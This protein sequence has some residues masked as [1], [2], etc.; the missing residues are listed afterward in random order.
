VDHLFNDN[1]A[2]RLW[3]PIRLT[4][5]F[6][7]AFP[8]NFPTV[9]GSPDPTETTQYSASFHQ[10]FPGPNLLNECRIG[11]FR[12]RHH[13]SHSRG[14]QAG[15]SARHGA[16]AP[17]ILSFTGNSP[18]RSLS[19][20]RREQSH[21]TGISV[22]RQPDLGERPPLVP[23]AALKCASTSDPGYD[24]FGGVPAPLSG[25][26][27][28]AV[29]NIN[30]ITGIGWNSG[31]AQNTLLDLAGSL[32]LCFPKRQFSGSANPVFLPGDEETRYRTWR[33]REAPFTSKTI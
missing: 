6:N 21:H 7:V 17:Y 32:S 11:A 20:G 18:V 10:R 13:C 2:C 23:K 30:T 25:A 22:R 31:T 14:C 4:T 3:L 5:A 29:Q 16:G 15:A 12:P 24:A 8:Q 28:V 33:Q 9:P 19:L 1:I 27:A 26:G